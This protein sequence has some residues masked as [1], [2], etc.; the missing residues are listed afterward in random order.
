MVFKKERAILKTVS[1]RM[2]GITVLLFFCYLFTRDP[3]TSLSITAFQQSIQTI[4]YYGHEWVW[5]RNGSCDNASTCSA[6]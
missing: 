4:V 2:I 6:R 1:Y 5:E 3:L